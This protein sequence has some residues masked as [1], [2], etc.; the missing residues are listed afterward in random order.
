MNKNEY[1][2]FSVIVAGNE[3]EKLM[4]KYNN[5]VKTK[6]YVV[7]HYSDA[8]ILK[9]KYINIYKNIVD[10]NENNDFFKNSFNELKKLSASEF[11]TFFT[12]D[13]EHD[14]ITGDA[15]SD[16]NP[17]GK[18]L[19]Y[20]IGKHLCI[21]FKLKEDQGES[22]QNLKKN[23]DWNAMHKNNIK[24]YES[25][26]DVVMNGKVPITDEETLIYNNMK[27]RIAYF[28]KYENRENYVLVNTSFWAY[29]FLSEETGWVDMDDSTSQFEWIKSF[30]EKYILPLSDESLL[31][32]YECT[33]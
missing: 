23:I 24:I 19:T 1:N 10:N 29:A 9:S 32:I 2:H 30:Y 13:Y 16:I 17:N 27:E 5:N 21:P 18:W 25:A 4:E 22:F 33:K 31:T 28:Q 26:W 15:I 8:N 7:Y 11:F 3:P 14:E 6:P 12:K 20:S